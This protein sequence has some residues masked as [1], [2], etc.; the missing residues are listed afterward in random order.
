MLATDR[1][2]RRRRPPAR[3][4]QTLDPEGA[5]RGSREA[6]DKCAGNGYPADGEQFVEMELKA[7]AEQEKDDADFGHLVGQAGVGD[8]PRSVRADDNPGQQI[9]NNRGEADAVGEESKDQGGSQA[10]GQGQDQV[11]VV[12]AGYW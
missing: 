1:A 11:E 8:K 9:S 3:F 10:T 12:H 6:G 7:D 4:T 2:S 5:E